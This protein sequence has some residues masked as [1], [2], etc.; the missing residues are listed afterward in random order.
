VAGAVQEYTLPLKEAQTQ[1]ICRQSRFT[2]ESDA[3][4]LRQ[5]FWLKMPLDSN[6]LAKLIL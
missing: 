3:T 4:L 2:F 6:M 5:I 1:D